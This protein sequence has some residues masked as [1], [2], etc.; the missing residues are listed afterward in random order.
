[1]ILK[2]KDP[3]LNWEKGSQLSQQTK[4]K[5][6]AD[7]RNTRASQQH[8]KEKWARMEKI[9]SQ[10]SKDTGLNAKT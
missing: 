10:L 8:S 3:T 6:F 9:N 4:L 7:T 5:Q 2:S 1:M